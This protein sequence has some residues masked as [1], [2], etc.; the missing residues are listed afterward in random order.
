[1]ED[2]R[3]GLEVYLLSPLCPLCPWFST[4]SGQ[5]ASV[6]W[7]VVSWE[8]DMVAGDK[9]QCRCSLA[10]RCLLGSW[11]GQSLLR[12]TPGGWQLSHC[13]WLLTTAE[14]QCIKC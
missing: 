14:S 8:G 1:M 3:V 7:C 2:H 11:Q 6:L 9:T 4:S 5:M 13:Y 10:T 12:L